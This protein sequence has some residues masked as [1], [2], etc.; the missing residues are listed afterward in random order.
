MKQGGLASTCLHAYPPRLGPFGVSWFP[1]G[2][3]HCVRCVLLRP[4]PPSRGRIRFRQCYS[5]HSTFSIQYV[6]LMTGFSL[7]S[8]LISLNSYVYTVCVS[9]VV[10]CIPTYSRPWHCSSGCTFSKLA[11]G[12]R[13]GA[14][15]ARSAKN[16]KSVSR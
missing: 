12:V 4:P 8:H 9:E 7:R 16:I 13:Y 1:T 11:L 14:S 2:F 10:R 15:E 6:F 3:H 5:R